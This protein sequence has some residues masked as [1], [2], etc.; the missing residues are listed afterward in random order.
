MLPANEKRGTPIR[1]PRCPVI[2]CSKDVAF[3]KPWI[4]LAPQA[5]FIE[6]RRYQC[7]AFEHLA[8]SIGCEPTHSL[9][10]RLRVVVTPWDRSDGFGCQR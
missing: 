10:R 8:R 7:V 4:E 9:D 1:V 2:L 6:S 5:Q 3:E